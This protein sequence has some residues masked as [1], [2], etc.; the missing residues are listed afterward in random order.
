VAW[1]SLGGQWRLVR[2]GPV[3]SERIHPAAWLPLAGLLTVLA[4]ATSLLP[5]PFG[6]LLPPL[7]AAGA[8]AVAVAAVRGLATRLAKPAEATFQGQVIARWVEQRGDNNSDWDVSCIA[9]DDGERSWSFDVKDA[10]FGKLALGDTVTVRAAPR[11]GKLLS[12]VPLRDGTDHGA[13][14]PGQPAPDLMA[15]EPFLR[16]TPGSSNPLLTAKEVSAVVGRPVEASGFQLGMLGAVYRGAD[17]T[18]SL[19]VTRGAVGRLSY[20]P[21]RRWGRALPGIGD[22]AWQLARDQTVVFRVGG[23]T[24]KV[25]VSGSAARGLGPDVPP[26]LATAV[27]T[28]LAAW[29]SWPPVGDPPPGTP[30]E[31]S[32]SVSQP[33]GTSTEP[34][35]ISTEPR[36]TF[37]EPRGTFTEPR[38]TFSEPPGTFSEPPGTFSEPPGKFS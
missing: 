33:P 21:A 38:R 25:T 30:S 29:P 9:V 5:S 7:L 26:R 32:D 2:I 14:A 19:T 31:P 23:Y 34:R 15:D 35:G 13:A 24:G 28:R 8:V 17:L 18:V 1:S 4:F 27:A 36:G 11:S 12:L 16:V 10:A 20:G 6:Q 3:L 37:T 22:E